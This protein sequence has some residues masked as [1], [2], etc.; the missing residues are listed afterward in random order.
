[1]T[2]LVAKTYYTLRG[3]NLVGGKS[4]SPHHI[5]KC[6]GPRD[7]TAQIALLPIDTKLATTGDH[8][9]LIMEQTMLCGNAERR[10]AVESFVVEFLNSLLD[11]DVSSGTG[12]TP[13]AADKPF[14]IH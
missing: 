6:P 7:R 13:V 3:S 5:I 14:R 10:R 12:S 2:C 9:G 11:A 8:H 4:G 1:M